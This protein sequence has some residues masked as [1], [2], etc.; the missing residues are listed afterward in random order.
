M[1]L[2]RRSGVRIVPC[3]NRAFGGG[4]GGEGG[5]GMD[6]IILGVYDTV[7]EGRLSYRVW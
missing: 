5:S 7:P 2:I 4:G 3:S 1:R 6:K